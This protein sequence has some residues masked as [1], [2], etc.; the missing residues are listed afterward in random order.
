MGSRQYGETVR[1][2][3]SS[4][5][6]VEGGKLFMERENIDLGQHR[7][8]TLEGTRRYEVNIQRVDSNESNAATKY[9]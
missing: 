6:L 5:L 9:K 4:A 1:S 3:W 7:G 2:L 8:P